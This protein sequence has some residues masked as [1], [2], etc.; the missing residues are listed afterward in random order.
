MKIIVAHAGRQ[1][2][3]KTAEALEKNNLLHTYIT[4]VYNKPGSKTAFI[5]KLLFGSLKK[6]GQ[7]RQNQNIPDTK[8]VQYE[9]LI[10]LF[11]LILDRIPFLPKFRQ[12]I[13]D[14]VHDR[15]GIKVAKYAILQ[16]VDMVIMYD[17]NA[18]LAFEYL[19]KHAPHIKR[20][21][22]V[23]SGN[24][25]YLK[26][27]YDNDTRL[28]PDSEVLKE[29]ATSISDTM[30]RRTQREL[31]ASTYFLA[32][33]NFVKRSL[34]FSGVDEKNIFILPYG[35]DLNIFSKND[36]ES[37]TFKNSLQL[38]FVGH[39]AYRKGV[40]H[41]LKVVSQFPREQIELSIVGQFHNSSKLFKD[42]Q[43]YSNIHF[44]GFVNRENIAQV[45]K[46]ADV[47]VLPSLA[48]GFG[49]V[50]LEAM[51]LEV[52]AICTSNCGCSDIVEDMYNGFIIPV[53]N[54]KV[55]QERIQWFVDNK[56]EI[57]RMGQ[58]AHSTAST[59]SWD[60]YDS[61]LTKVVKNISKTI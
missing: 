59:F 7:N 32:G 28:Y 10:A 45:F 33:S 53:S 3:L 9:E 52:P 18:M 4:T 27:V 57:A 30:L 12:K 46:N 36:K 25:I 29:E 26:E 54:Q 48:E 50:T 11:L 22:D 5:N 17:T 47:F 34:L 41:L 19:K 49:L 6:R 37:K 15:F 31:K 13:R 2:S 35:V 38:L 60:N 43:H 55:L 44:L 14:Y 42:F 8:V 1:H 40:H 39:L 51:S 61:G 23:S 16:Q 20:L 21:L 56:H 58:Q 24:R